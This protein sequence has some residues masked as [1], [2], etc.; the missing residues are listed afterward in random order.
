MSNDLMVPVVGVRL[1][2]GRSGSTLLMQLLGTSPEIVFDDRYPSEYR[3]VS[4]FARL[5]SMMTEPFD[6][7]RHVGVTPFFF[8][9]QQRW[10][11]VPFRSDVIDVTALREP[12]LM[13][14][15]LAWSEVAR[16]RH[17]AIR[18]YAEKLAV[19]IGQIADASLPLRIIDLVRDPRDV[20]ASIRAFTASGIDGFGR[21]P[22]TDEREYLRNFVA[23]FGRGLNRMQQ[24][25][26]AGVDGIVVR[27]EDLI[28]DMPGESERIGSWLGV[29]LRPEVV[30][31]NRADYAHHTTSHTSVASIGR[32]RQDLSDAEAKFVADSL[33]EVA[34]PLGYGL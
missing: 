30:E 1:A 21:T 11:P 3:F 14:M 5:A 9:G 2:E 12:L 8:D 6:E 19:D 15:W 20:L 33:R 23:T 7:G 32:W 10:G 16:R 25:R 13:Q 24:E 29:D 26:P 34:A 31:A 18:W 17:P 22:D 28:V 4:Y 27:Y